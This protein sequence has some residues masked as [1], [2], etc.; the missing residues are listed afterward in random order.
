MFPY[1]TEAAAS[2]A[3]LLLENYFNLGSEGLITSAHKVSLFMKSG[4]VKKKDLLNNSLIIIRPKKQK[5]G[6]ISSQ[7]MKMETME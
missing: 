4:Y 6:L 1:N 5:C 7:H 2:A 3:K